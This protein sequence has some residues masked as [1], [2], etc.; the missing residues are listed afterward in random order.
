M[1]RLAALVIT[2][3]CLLG[4]EPAP[5]KAVPVARTEVVPSTPPTPPDAAPAPVPVVAQ[6]PPVVDAAPAPLPQ[7]ASHPGL[8]LVSAGAEPR[9]PLRYQAAKGTKQHMTM[10]MAMTMTL[11][12]NPPILFP[13]MVIGADV[14]A[15]DVDD[16]GDMT[17]EIELTG[18]D[19]KDVAGSQ[20][21]ADQVKAQM[22]DV[23]GMKTQ[24]RVDPLG[25]MTDLQ[26]TAIQTMQ[27]QQMGF[28][29]LVAALPAEPVGVGAKWKIKQK[30]DQ[31]ALRLDQ[32]VTVE[33]VEVTATT[34]K[35]KT[36]GRLS[37][38]AQKLDFQGAEVDVERTTGSS[39]TTLSID[40]TRL[41]P[42]VRGSVEMTM[43]MS[44]GG[45]K[46]TMTN[47]SKMTMKATRK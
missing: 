35:L 1:Q 26:G 43:K 14:T 44:A 19:V 28:D 39:Q 25:Q 41:V 32:T 8:E 17:L 9:F 4:C 37:A 10:T 22:G 24:M 34:A 3:T 7:K 29:Q 23:A 15:V 11:T 2:A 42:T 18:A 30:I 16:D 40:F 47:K 45:E 6:V 33:V 36:R 38:P 5:E 21:P 12:P 13:E 46:A 31:G 27:Q 20:I